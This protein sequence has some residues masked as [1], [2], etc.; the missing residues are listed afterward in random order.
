MRADNKTSLG[1]FT[2]YIKRFGL[3]HTFK[4]LWKQVRAGNLKDD[5]FIIKGI[6]DGRY[7]FKGP[8]TVQIDLTDSCNNDCICCW[9]NSPL[10]KSKDRVNEPASLDRLVVLRT[11]D[12]LKEIGVREIVLS[13]GGEPFI[14]PHLMDIVRYIKKHKIYCQL[15]TNFT[16][17]TQH[18]IKELVDLRLDR[19][20]VSLWAG[21]AKTYRL[22]H[23]NKEES[24]FDE[25][26]NKL[27][28]L[29]GIKRRK[30][31]PLVRIH[32]IINVLNYNELSQMTDFACRVKA[33][34]VSFSVMDS[35]A[36]KT[37]ALLLNDEQRQVVL[38]SIKE[39]NKE[40]PVYEIEEFIRRISYK[41]AVSGDYDEEIIDETP[42]YSG[43]L[44]ARIKADGNV[45]PCLKSHRL[46]VGNINNQSFKEIWN[47]P[48]QRDFREK[49]KSFGKSDPYFSLMGNGSPGLSGCSRVCDDL[50]RNIMMHRKITLYPTARLMTKI[51]ALENKLS[52]LN[53][54]AARLLKICYLITVV[55]AYSLFLKFFRLI[56]KIS[57]FPGE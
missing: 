15:Y 49:A 50:T 16:L 36:S 17:A 10:V 7:A 19:L 46:Q 11:I 4:S 38:N 39:L 52:G 30:K 37:N 44:F 25:I 26:R 32:N 57:I 41:G 47:S 56:K 20:I 21:T 31:V 22:L 14:Y 3:K 24:H 45:N 6:C 35:V 42:C 5:Y 2:G 51:V 18:S 40:L 33:D 53:K 23:P 1:F 8:L 12:E 43:W 28:Y 55:V 54:K 48:L 27:I 13:G 29:S 34:E 9:C